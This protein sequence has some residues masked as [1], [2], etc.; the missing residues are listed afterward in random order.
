MKLAGTVAIITG[1][2][3]G[4]GRSLA[5]RFAREGAK[6][7]ICCRSPIGIEEVA[8]EIRHATGGEV[9][10]VKADVSQ[11][12]D[13]DRL[14]A[15]TLKQFGKLDVLIN[16]AAVLTP[17][18]PLQTLK[19]TDWDQTMAANLRGP[20]LCTRA[21]LP[22]FIAQK[23]GVIINVSSGAGKRPA[24]GWGPYAVSKAGLE[25]LT[26]SVAEEVRAHG[27][28]VNSVNPGGTRTAMRAA[29]YPQEDPMR[30]PE[31]EA[32]TGVFV[33][34]ASDASTETGQSV[35]APEWLA[36]HADWREATRSA[37]A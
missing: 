28:R 24:P 1:A 11:E 15:M 37:P 32:L 17:R 26:A 13:V 33:Y 20:Y 4:L 6:I 16:N 19:V 3:R 25:S 30:L 10:A 36:T 8:R 31:P 34:L 29:A 5:M 7:A 2:S 22:H 9:L 12:R 18:G 35:D 23:R 21:V 14:A 27:I